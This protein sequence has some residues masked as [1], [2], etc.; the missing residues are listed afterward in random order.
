[1]ELRDASVRVT[2][3]RD[4]LGFEACR[5]FLTAG[6]RVRYWPSVLRTSLQMTLTPRLKPSA[7]W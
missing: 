1:M 4:G 2:G 5:A 7:P 3:G 6:A